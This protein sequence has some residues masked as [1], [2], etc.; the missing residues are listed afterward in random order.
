MCVCFLPPIDTLKHLL[1]TLTGRGGCQL[2]R[3][4]PRR[5]RH[6]RVQHRVRQRQRPV[7]D[8]PVNR[9]HNLHG[10]VGR[11]RRPSPQLRDARRAGGRHQGRVSDWRHRQRHRADN[12]PR[13]RRQ[14]ASVHQSG[15]RVSHLR[16][17]P[18]RRHRQR[19]RHRRR[20]ILQRF[21]H[22]RPVR[23][24]Q[25]Q[26]LFRWTGFLEGSAEHWDQSSVDCY[27]SRT[28]RRAK[29]YAVVCPSHSER[30]KLHHSAT[31][32]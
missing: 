21:H 20:L 14:L 31:S 11:G 19:H 27:R 16:L 5:H 7:R 2:R 32:R 29:G 8:P 10:H 23:R 22:L 17:H 4:R 26:G 1:H 9:G 18:S 28:G 15:V 6:S 30:G 12:F 13:H 25:C 3:H 24:R